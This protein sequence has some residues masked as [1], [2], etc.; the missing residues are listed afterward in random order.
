V[1]E[2]LTADISA[3]LRKTA[4][5][6]RLRGQGWATSIALMIEAADKLDGLLESLVQA[7]RARDE[8]AEECGNLRLGAATGNVMEDYTAEQ[9]AELT[10]ER[11]AMRP[12]VEAVAGWRELAGDDLDW[13]SEQEL[14]AAHDAYLASRT[15]VGA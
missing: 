8:L 6:A 12:V 11:D 7:E 10:A 2:R 1:A 14:A 15:E 9:V 3:D 13:A 5:A 4:E